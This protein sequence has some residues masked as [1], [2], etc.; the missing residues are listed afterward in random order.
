[1]VETPAALS[2][3][4]REGGRTP[5]PLV[6]SREAGRPEGMTLQGA[7]QTGHLDEAVQLLAERHHAP[8]Q[9]RIAGGKRWGAFVMSPA[10]VV[11]FAHQHRNSFDM[12]MEEVSSPHGRG[13]CVWLY[14]RG[15]EQ[16]CL[17]LVGLALVTVQADWLQEQGAPSAEGLPLKKS[18][19]D[20]HPV[21]FDFIGM[22]LKEARRPA[23]AKVSVDNISMSCRER[24][25]TLGWN[26][27]EIE[28][29]YF[30]VQGKERNAEAITETQVLPSAAAGALGPRELA[31][32][33]RIF[34]CTTGARQMNDALCG[35]DAVLAAPKPSRVFGAEIHDVLAEHR[36][37]L[38]IS[39][40]NGLDMRSIPLNDN[41]AKYFRKPEGTLPTL[42]G[43]DARMITLSF[44]LAALVELGRPWR[45]KWWRSSWRSAA[46]AWRGTGRMSGISGGG[47][48]STT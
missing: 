25:Y 6:A 7:I 47:G 22:V 3:A 23:G 39:V 37:P 26:R 48:R 43:P 31:L 8:L 12:Y 11:D 13:L 27:Q 5:G 35:V 34:A 33:Q 32:Q 42:S 24:L 30:G 45:G 36:D 46:A 10:E 44:G 18:P 4:P 38:L 28:M 15:I 19:M 1:M 29:I 17:R 9:R 21:Q 14:P 16:G 20:G 2:V 40:F 41:C